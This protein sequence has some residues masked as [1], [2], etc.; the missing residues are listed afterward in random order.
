[1]LQI[2]NNEKIKYEKAKTETYLDFKDLSQ[3]LSLALGLFQLLLLQ[4]LLLCLVFLHNQSLELTGE[5]PS[6]VQ[7]LEDFL[8]LGDGQLLVIVQLFAALIISSVNVELSLKRFE[9]ISGF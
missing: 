3:L 5:L 7:G 2:E 6:E 1:L 4:E 8:V 9:M